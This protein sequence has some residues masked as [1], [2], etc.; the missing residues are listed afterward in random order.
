M[1]LY[2]R[3]AQTGE[4]R[5]GLASA[6]LRYEVLASLHEALSRSSKTQ[7]DLAKALGIR[8]SAVNSVFKGTGNLRVNTVAEYLH[9]LGLE[10]HIVVTPVGSGRAAFRRMSTVSFPVGARPAPDSVL[11]RKFEEWHRTAKSGEVKVSVTTAKRDEFA[12]V[13]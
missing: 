5:R 11:E 10:G 6:R 4:G 7:A 2:E 12:T 13:A 3:L 9:E 8:R 1:S